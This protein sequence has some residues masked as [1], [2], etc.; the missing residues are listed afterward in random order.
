MRALLPLGAVI[1]LVLGASVQTGAAETA[2]V[3]VKTQPLARHVLS[4]TISG[5]G[6]VDIDPLGTENITIPRA[7][8]VAQLLVSQGEAVKKGAGLLRFET[9]P[10][11]RVNYEQ[12]RTGADAAKGEL[13]RIQDLF[14]RQLA[15]RSQVEAA[16]K[17]LHDAEAE[18]SAQEKM[19]TDLPSQVLTAPFDGIVSALLVSQGER[20]QPGA[21][22]LR[23]SRRDRLRVVLGVEPEDAPRI[24]RGMRVQ[25][26]PVFDGT[27]RT[28]GEVRTVSNMVDPQSG[29]VNVFI[30]LVRGRAGRLMPGTRM[31]GRIALI[32]RRVF[33][34]PR[35]AV[36]SDEQG[37]YIFVVRKGRGRRVNVRT[38]IE[39]DGLVGIDGPV[40]AGDRVVVQGNYE[41]REGMAVRE[42][43]Q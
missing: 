24:G 14:S 7:G 33:A 5:Y 10:Q 18:L 11:E 4:N 39:A 8:Q 12:A 27:R 40:A 36:L 1:L 30:R 23:L 15:T 13:A 31:E 26:V 28:T 6:I 17:A 42:E 20:I 37:S 21:T 9:G 43:S 29:L 41:L 32:S 34:V 3:L 35:Q 22:A 2:S 38:G 16:R 19:G 25:L